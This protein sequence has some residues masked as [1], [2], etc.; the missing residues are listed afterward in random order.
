MKQL[1]LDA[2]INATQQLEQSLHYYH[3]DIVQHDAGLKLQLRAAAILSFEFT[4]E[5][6]WK[7]LRRYLMLVE[8]NPA[9]VANLS[10]PDLI[11]LSC[12]RGLLRSEL[13]VWKGFRQD[14]SITSHTYNN[15]KA[16]M[17]FAHLPFFLEETQDL[18][19]RLQQKI[20]VL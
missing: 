15:Q 10:Y 16:E 12:D 19:Q 7:T 20:A 13:S 6:A 8:P 17:I 11:R 14:R 5:L 4:Y 3:S 2:L 9:E 1:I 18:L